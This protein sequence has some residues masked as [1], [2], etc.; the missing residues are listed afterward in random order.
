MATYRPEQRGRAQ[1]K[2]SCE[3]AKAAAKEK[4]LTAQF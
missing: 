2:Q 4:A 3:V 1:A